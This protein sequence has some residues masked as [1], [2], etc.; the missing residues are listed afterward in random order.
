MKVNQI[1][2]FILLLIIFNSQLSPLPVLAKESSTSATPSAHLQSKLKALQEEI[3]SKANELK[4][5]ISKKLQN[6]AFVGFVKTKSD[7]S[8]TLTTKSGIKNISVH[9]YTTY[10]GKGD[11]KKNLTLKNISLENYLVVLGDVDETDTLTADKIIKPASPAPK[12]EIIFGFVKN[13][14]QTSLTINDI[15]QETK[16]YILDKKTVYRLG[17]K[18]GAFSGL[19]E[20]QKVIVVNLPSGENL[21]ARFIYIFPEVNIN[22]TED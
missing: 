4:Q 22:N 16:N 11:D 6:K 1:S 3:A 19:K 14:S 2:K 5:E 17:Q 18:T 20:G 21:K 15:N 10:I 12:K 7:N 13:L 9:E 8:L